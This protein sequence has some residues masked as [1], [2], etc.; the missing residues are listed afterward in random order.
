[1]IATLFFATQHTTTKSD[2]GGAPL[3]VNPHMP[4]TTS[5]RL[6]SLGALKKLLLNHPIGRLR[7][8]LLHPRLPG[9]PRIPRPQHPP[10]HPNPSLLPHQHTL[11][12]LRRH[13]LLLL[14]QCPAQLRPLPSR[15]NLRLLQLTLQSGLLAAATGPARGPDL[16]QG[17]RT[18]LL[19]LSLQ[20][21]PLQCPRLPH[22]R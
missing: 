10:G 13:L 2:R 18:H 5:T 19:R 8:T 17:E 14:H 11:L 16:D 3:L 20:H 21:R 4:F 22:P 15:P 1:M 7:Q 9:F 6:T 12:L